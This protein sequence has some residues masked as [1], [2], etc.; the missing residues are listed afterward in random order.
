MWYTDSMYQPAKK[1]FFLVSGIVLALVFAVVAS[2]LA[3]FA[4][5]D[6]GDIEDDISKI[7]KKLKKE[8]EE[9]NALQQD[10]NQINSSL[11]STQTLIQ[12]VQNLLNQ[13]EQ[14]IEQKDKEIVNL[15]Q[16]LVLERHVLRGLLQE[17]YAGGD[18][19]SVGIVVAE[20][21]LLSLFQENDNLF[22]TQ[23]KMQEVIREISEMRTKISEEKTSLEDTKA[24]HAELLAIKNKQKQALVSEQAETKDEL[25]DQQ[26][27]IN[28]L[29]KELNELQGDLSKLT[30]KSYD[31][32]DIREAVEFAS[33]KTGVPKGVLY[34]F[35]KMETNLGA[36]TGQC[37]Y[38]EVEK[39]AIAQYKSLL[40]KNKKWQASIDL[41]Y[42]RQKL[43]YALVDDLGY[44]DSK[45]VSC[46]PRSYIGQGGAM[47]V[48][49]FMADV[50]NG[51]ASQIAANTGHKTP[52]PWNLTDGVMAMAL[53]LKKAGATSDSTSTI[54]KA[55]I[56]YLG[57]FSPGYYNGIVYWSK[58]YKSLFK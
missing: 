25:E 7:E 39:G 44:S 29:K 21:D 41:L 58:N 33:G 22:S 37:T 10:L 20:T 19:H 40:K 32:K 14:T 42:R 9:L 26:S 17:M 52:D 4:E 35:L 46:N 43:F 13:T 18:M 2:P 57:T 11:T 16:Q 1:Y 45:K 24:D 30:G 31:A 54:R 36:N 50:W 23:E 15:E 53:K 55:S 56:S 38:K 28:R 47:G 5:E 34:G 48:P 51:Y 8:T 12:R 6:A 49:Q 3:V 27:I